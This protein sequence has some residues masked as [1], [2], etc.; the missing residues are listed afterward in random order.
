MRV[1]G[2]PVWSSA[3]VEARQGQVTLRRTP[4]VSQPAVHQVSRPHRW[5]DA[6]GERK[7]HLQH[8]GP[9]GVPHG[10]L[11]LD[12]HH[13][14]RV[15]VDAVV[16][17]LLDGVPTRIATHRSLVPPVDPLRP[18]G[19]AAS[20]A[21]RSKGPFGRLLFTSRYTCEFEAPA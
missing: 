7:G 19:G 20:I 11:D 5:D 14:Q 12:E 21:F 6:W 16:E 17:R 1:A 13:L 2:A 9:A 10:G 3:L 8:V 18:G 4:P 15:H